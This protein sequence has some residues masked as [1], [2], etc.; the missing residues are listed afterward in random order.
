[1]NERS[2]AEDEGAAT[3]GVSRDSHHATGLA[4]ADEAIAEAGA[5]RSSTRRSA[6]TVG[7]LPIGAET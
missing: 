2:E 5:T 6:T 3:L 4:A 1:M 7:S